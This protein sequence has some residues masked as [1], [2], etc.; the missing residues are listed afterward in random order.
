MDENPLVDRLGRLN[1][2]K[3]FAIFDYRGEPIAA[4]PAPG[5]RRPGAG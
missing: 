2:P 3:D 4:A 5:R 1:K